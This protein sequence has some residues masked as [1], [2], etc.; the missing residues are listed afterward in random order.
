MASKATDECE[1]DPSFNPMKL[2][3]FRNREYCE[4][5]GLLEL[6]QLAMSD[7]KQQNMPAWRPIPT[8]FYSMTI[9]FI[10]AVV[11]FAFGVPLLS[12]FGAFIRVVL[13]AQIVEVKQRY[14]DICPAPGPNVKCTITIKVPE[15][16]TKTVQLYYQLE[17]FYQNH[18]I[19][20]KSV[21][22]E[23]LSGEDLP[24]TELK[25]CDP[26]QRITDIGSAHDLNTFYRIFHK[27]SQDD[28]RSLR[29]ARAKSSS[30]IS[31][32]SYCQKHV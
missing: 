2:E 26:V 32:W 12:I 17:N 10:I 3:P 29:L 24:V 16:M 4:Q 19:Y 5:K 21:S 14:D 27:S 31:V 23:Q 1:E 22:T 18:R 11:C 15:K 20:M 25:D 7:F 8:L 30:C 6:H 13:S 9:F 28:R